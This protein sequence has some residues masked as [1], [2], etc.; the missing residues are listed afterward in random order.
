MRPY[1]GQVERVVLAAVCLLLRHDLDRQ[2]PARKLAVLDAHKQ[3]S[4]IAFPVLA[5]DCLSLAVGQVFNA[6]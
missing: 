4:H 5:N 2:A 3:I 6:L 1:L